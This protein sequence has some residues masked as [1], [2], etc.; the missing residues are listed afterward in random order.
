MA[1]ALCG[2][3]AAMQHLADGERLGVAASKVGYGSTALLATAFGRVTGTSP[4][5]NQSLSMTAGAGPAVHI[6]L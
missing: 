4:G 2:C 6:L 3:A 1:A 5:G